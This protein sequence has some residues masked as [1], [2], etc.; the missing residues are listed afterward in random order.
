[1]SMAKET[2]GTGVGTMGGHLMIGQM[3]SLP[4]MPAQAGQTA[5]VAHSGLTLVNV[6]QLAKN[7]MGLV[8]I[9]ASQKKTKKK[10]KRL[11]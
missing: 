4:G 5:R 8:D 2:M 6:G 11:I 10:S 1:M 3:G 9:V 7:A